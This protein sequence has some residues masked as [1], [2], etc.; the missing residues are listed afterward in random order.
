MAAGSF[1]L[2]CLSASSYHCRHRA[3]DDGRRHATPLFGVKSSSSSR[4]SGLKR[5]EQKKSFLSA[6]SV[7]IEGQKIDDG[8]NILPLD[9]RQLR[10][11]E[12]YL[13]LKRFQER[14]G[15]CN[16]PFRHKEDGATLGLW[17]NTQR[18]LQRKEKLDPNRENRLEELGFEWGLT[19]A[20]WEEIFSLLQQFKK[21][22]GHCNVPQSHGEG[23]IKLGAWVFTQRQLERSKKINPE[24]QKILEGTGFEWGLTLA[25][26]EEIYAR[27]KQVM[28]RE[29]HCNVPRSRKED[30]ATLGS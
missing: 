5:V 30:G 25:T 8:V 24:R 2:L 12:K 10:W 3:T 29:G 26:W 4:S 13:L 9:V 28:K 14:E 20:T 6:Q 27:S 11:E 18:Q 7:A 16:V 21:R 17:A 15:H 23:G 1:F 19:S 22:E